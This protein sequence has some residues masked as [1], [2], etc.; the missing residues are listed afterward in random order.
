MFVAHETRLPLS[1]ELARARLASLIQGG[2]L[3]SVCEDVYGEG[4]T[5]LLRVGLP[6]LGISRLVRVQFRDLVTHGESAVLAFRWEAVGS[7]GGLFPALDADLT[8]R[9]LAAERS[10]LRI[11]GAYRPPLG[12]LGAAMDRAI[13]NRVATATI[14]DLVLR[15]AA[16]IEQK[17]PA[18]GRVPELGH[19]PGTA[20]GLV[21]GSAAGRVPGPPAGRVLG[22]AAGRVL[23]PAAGRFPEDPDG[24]F[25]IERG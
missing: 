4:M 9:P 11:D 25:V 19:L 6:G 12:S 1:Y 5:A 14:R 3:V 15:M 13:L 17:M 21:S 16:G 2:L 8:L 7:A 23:G 20:A 22:P 10:L 24:P 18:P